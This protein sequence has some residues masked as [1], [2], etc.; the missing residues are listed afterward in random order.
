MEK[1]PIL[2]RT[3]KKVETA[4]SYARIKTAFPQRQMHPV[5]LNRVF[6]GHITLPQRPYHGRAAVDRHDTV[7]HPGV[8]RSDAE[9]QMQ[10]TAVSECTPDVPFVVG[11]GS[12]RGSDPAPLPCVIVPMRSFGQSRHRFGRRHKKVWFTRSASTK[13][14]KKLNDPRL[15]PELQRYFGKPIQSSASNRCAQMREIGKRAVEA[16]FE[17]GFQISFRS[18]SMY[19]PPSPT[20]AEP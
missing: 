5:G 9:Q 6:S 20:P 4:I 7:E 1:K 14:D 18:H 8:F 16:P 10:A 13:S 19:A 12:Q 2:R 17:P 3:G 15:F 11:M